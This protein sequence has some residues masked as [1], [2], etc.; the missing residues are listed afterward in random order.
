MIMICE[1]HLDTVA[2]V[3]L[4][5]LDGF[6]KSAFYQNKDRLSAGKGQEFCGNK[7]H[8]AVAIEICHGQVI[9]VA[10]IQDG[11]LNRCFLDPLFKR[12]SYRGHHRHYC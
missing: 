3:T 4:F 10:N 1:R 11:L 5:R 2:N 9:S 6:E 8:N 12:A 7:I